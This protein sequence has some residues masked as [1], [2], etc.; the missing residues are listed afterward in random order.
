MPPTTVAP[1]SNQNALTAAR[2][3]TRRT[4]SVV[5]RPCD[6]ASLA[7]PAVALEKSVR[8]VRVQDS[9]CCLRVNRRQR[10]DVIAAGRP[11]RSRAAFSRRLR[12]ASPRT[13]PGDDRRSTVRPHLRRR[14]TWPGARSGSTGPP[15]V[16]PP[17]R[18][19]RPTAYRASDAT[20][21]AVPR[22]GRSTRFLNRGGAAGGGQGV[23]VAGRR[24]V[25]G[26][27]A[28]L[29][30]RGPSHRRAL[31]SGRTAASPAPTGDR[32]GSR[33]PALPRGFAVYMAAMVDWARWPDSCCASGSCDVVRAGRAA[34][35]VPLAAA[36]RDPARR[37]GLGAGLAPRA[38]VLPRS[39]RRHR[40]IPR[41]PA[42]ARGRRC[43]YARLQ[44]FSGSDT[45]HP[46]VNEL[47]GD[48][49]KIFRLFSAGG[50]VGAI[51]EETCSA[52]H[53]T[54]T[55]AAASPGPRRRRSW[56]RSLPRSTPQG[57]AAGAGARRHR[58]QLRHPPRVARLG[59][60]TGGSARDQQRGGDAAFGSASALVLPTRA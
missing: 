45:S 44:K 48:G 32:H 15:A 27:I 46:I 43:D 9:L 14:S 56:R 38:R 58:L 19:M 18:S 41:G 31:C 34:V 11:S 25:V 49:W 10:G 23:L 20:M 16:S 35:R 60:R 28:L 17:N 8:C 36:A 2:S 40:R 3:T 37:A 55:S 29:T 52:A 53:S 33:P 6:N 22:G 57:W 26:G 7:E 30:G 24:T 47:G 1:A 5:G 39:R 59:H 21:S 50:G 51:V 13:A 42:C 12:A 54:T 4:G